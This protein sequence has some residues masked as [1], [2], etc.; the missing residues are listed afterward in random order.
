MPVTPKL[1]VWGLWGKHVWPGLFLWNVTH[2][3]NSVA[4]GVTYAAEEGKFTDSRCM[5][6][7]YVTKCILQKNSVMG[8]VFRFL[9]LPRPDYL[10]PENDTL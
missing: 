8:P 7:V 3:G 10:P 4:C 2:E 5:Y 6:M 1:K 9:R